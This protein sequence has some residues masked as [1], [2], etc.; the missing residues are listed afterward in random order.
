MNA[1]IVPA[2]DEMWFFAQI[3]V[4]GM[5]EDQPT[6]GL[7]QIAFEYGTGD[8]FA[9]GNVVGRVGKD[10]VELFGTTFQI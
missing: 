7:Q 6:L 8:C 5:F 2:L 9:A 1:S 4:F 10:D 3:Q